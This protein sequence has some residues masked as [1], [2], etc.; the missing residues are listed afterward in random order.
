MVHAFSPSTREAEAGE[1][2][3]IQGR[4]GAQSKFQDMEKPYLGKPKTRWDGRGELKSQDCLTA[5][6][7]QC[8]CLDESLPINY[9]SFVIIPVWLLV[10]K[11]SEPL[12]SGGTQNL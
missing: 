7:V 10:T 5:D 9:N 1:S 12:D 2:L 6:T 8:S 3:G 4:P 11:N